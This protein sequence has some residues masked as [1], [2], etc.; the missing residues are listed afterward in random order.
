MNTESIPI[1]N[2]EPIYLHLELDTKYCSDDEVQILKKYANI[3]HGST[4]SRD[5]LI[6]YDMTIRALHYTIQKLFGWMGKYDYVMKLPDS[7]FDYITKAEPEKV[8]ELSGVLFKCPTEMD[9]EF[10]VSFDC[11]KLTDF[12]NRFSNYYTGPYA[13]FASEEDYS[14]ITREVL[15]LLDEITEENK[16]NGTIDDDVLSDLY[17]GDPEED[18]KA[19]INS[20]KLLERLNVASVLTYE[21]DNISTNL[22]YVKYDS[23]KEYDNESGMQP[24]VL[25]LTY[26]LI[27][28]YDSKKK[29]TVNVTMPEDFSALTFDKGVTYEE[30]VIA[31]D[32]VRESYKP[33]CIFRDGANVMEN[34]TNLPGFCKFLTI[35]NESKDAKEK[36]AVFKYGR[37]RDWYMDEIDDP[38]VF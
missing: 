38:I 21:G 23:V 9:D 33:Y 35:I 5:I 4:I 15:S 28:I 10:F 12:E 25:P 37:R 29:W 32:K 24:K 1:N 2:H 27:Y 31:K 17:S 16:R 34:L 26:K 19:R 11:P 30:I 18:E 6:P 14:T 7:I 13:D 3:K 22:K 8:L 20:N 36:K